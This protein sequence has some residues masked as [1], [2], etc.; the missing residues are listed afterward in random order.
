MMEAAFE[1]KFV[2]VREH[3]RLALEGGCSQMTKDKM[4]FS[5]SFSFSSNIGHYFFLHVEKEKM[6]LISKYT[7]LWRTFICILALIRVFLFIREWCLDWDWG[8]VRTGFMASVLLPVLIQLGNTDVFL[9]FWCS[10]SCWRCAASQNSRTCGVVS[11][12]AKPSYWL[13]FTK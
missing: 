2:T 3:N 8:L 9:S 6:F 4:H 1:V 10:W 11:W 5:F 7:N 12:P 13:N